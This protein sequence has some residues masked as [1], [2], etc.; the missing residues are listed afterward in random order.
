M[1]Q[2][3]LIALKL[4]EESYFD[5]M[6]AYFLYLTYFIITKDEYESLPKNR[7]D[8]KYWTSLMRLAVTRESTVGLPMARA[9]IIKNLDRL[10]ED[11][12]L[13]ITL[14]NKT[15]DD[16]SIERL[17]QYI[18]DMKR[19]RDVLSKSSL[20]IKSSAIKLLTSFLGIIPIVIALITAIG[21]SIN[22]AV[23]SF[24]EI[25]FLFYLIIFYI[26][27]FGLMFYILG[28]FSNR[29]AARH[30]NIPE[31]EAKFWDLMK[32]YPIENSL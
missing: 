26:I 22:S 27:Y 11:F 20:N 2:D 1:P 14:I 5:L 30:T 31:F 16:E 17:E 21:I 4:I 18:G 10:I 8:V 6:G 9:R 32:N 3:K 19:L 13:L 24:N 7:H 23:S 12:T 29:A 28:S 25:S 15:R